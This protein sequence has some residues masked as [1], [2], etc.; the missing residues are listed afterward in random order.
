M[1]IKPTARKR[2]KITPP[3]IAA[4]VAVL[5]C[6]GVGG[7]LL[8]KPKVDESPYRTAEVARG[9]VTSSVSASGR[10]QALV[11]VDVGSQ[12]SGQITQVNV[13]FNDRV[14]KGQI[15]AVL[16]PQTYTSRVRQGQAQVAASTA[17]RNQAQAQANVALANYN[18]TKALFDKGF[19]AQALLD[20]NLAAY[21]ASQAQVAAASA[22]IGQSQASLAAQQ[23]DLSR[24]TITSPI[25]GIVIDRKIE[26]GNTVA[27][28]L[29][30][31]VL[32]TIAQDL[33]QLEVQI[34]VGE[35]DVGQLREGQNVNFTVDAFPDDSFR[36]VVTQVRKQ[37]TTENNVTAY[38]V[39]AEAE[40]PDMKLLPGMTANA[41]IVLQERRNVLKVPTAALR[42]K[43]ADAPAATARPGA[44]GGAT[45]GGGGFGPPGGGFG[46]PG[47]GGGG[48]GPPGGGFG[49]GAQGPGQ[50]AARRAGG[51]GAGALV[52]QLGLDADQTRKVTAIMTEARQKAQAEAGDDR[53]KL[54]A[55]MQKSNQDAFA[56]I[57]PLLKPDQKAKLAQVRATFGQRRGAGAGGATAMTAGTVY[58]LRD[59]EAVAVPVMVGG[60]DGTS[61]E[62]VGEIKEGDE[63]ITGGGPRPKVQARS[64]FGIGGARPAGGGG[65]G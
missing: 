57:E 44:A 48:F 20:A 59:G 47:G 65:G 22:Q 34:S 32:F 50:G 10:L 14:R 54:R 42:W 1:A 51:A 2:F 56:K 55:A 49:G 60:T 41:D 12:I 62:V 53:T 61:S 52:Q 11:T 33:S 46:P 38:L 29:N 25:D 6:L 58:V 28:S 26:P 8:F 19:V 17:Q 23:V 7:W 45:V 37:P 16:D 5:L 39:I 31:P 18:R 15:L 21:R 13:D 63:V 40:N 4:T 35:A 36:G 24:T 9:D 30:A 64:M 27:A 43:P 3:R